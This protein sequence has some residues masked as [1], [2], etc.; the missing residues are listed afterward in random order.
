MVSD[1]KPPNV[2]A[3]IAILYRL[4]E[5]AYAHGRLSPTTMA[6]REWLYEH[7]RVPVGMT[8]RE[9][10]ESSGLRWGRPVE[11]HLPLTG[12]PGDAMLRL[13]DNTAWVFDP[14][15]VLFM[16]P[17]VPQA[18]EGL[19]AGL[20]HPP[21]RPQP[22]PPPG[23]PDP[24]KVLAEVRE[25]ARDMR[26]QNNIDRLRGKAERMLEILEW[27]RLDEEDFVESA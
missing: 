22:P 23:F 2:E 21:G 8:R 18:G 24:R 14:R 11:E 4:A 16:G 1:V 7:G 9:Y 15:W 20:P 12:L 25:L 26:H 13:C 6:V 5:R 10:V 19:T 3:R 27:F 17:G